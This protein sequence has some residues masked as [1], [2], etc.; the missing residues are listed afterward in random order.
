MKEKAKVC[1]PKDSSETTKTPEEIK[2][3]YT[4]SVV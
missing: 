2:E 1:Q 3:E 4:K